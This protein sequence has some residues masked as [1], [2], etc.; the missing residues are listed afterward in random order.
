MAINNFAIV[1]DGWNKPGIPT[2]ANWYHSS[3]RMLLITDGYFNLELGPLAVF[4]NGTLLI[5]QSFSDNYLIDGTTLMVRLPWTQDYE[6]PKNSSTGRAVI[7]VRQ[8]LSENYLG[9][10]IDY[11][12][13]ALS[14]DY[15]TDKLKFIKQPFSENYKV[16]KK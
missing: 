3:Q 15:E 13:I 4:L 12:R 8:S 9:D 10:G 14:D 6:V 1:M 16:E 2:G 5:R 7:L 11:T